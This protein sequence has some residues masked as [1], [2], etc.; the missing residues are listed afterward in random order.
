MALDLAFSTLLN[1]ASAVLFVALGAWALSLKPRRPITVAFGWFAI[2][3]GATFVYRNAG[4]IVGFDLENRWQ[5]P[6]GLAFYLAFVVLIWRLL[7][8]AD[9]RA[10]RRDVLALA[11]LALA[12]ALIMRLGNLSALWQDP[13]RSTGS[14]LREG[15]SWAAALVAPVRLLSGGG[16]RDARRQAGLVAAA[17]AIFDGAT[18]GEALWGL[19]ADAV[20]V[21]GIANVVLPAFV[22]VPLWLVVAARDEAD[23]RAARNV[24]WTFTAA[25]ILGFAFFP[26]TPPGELQ[27]AFR[28][29]TRVAMMAA[30]AYAILRHQVLGLDVRV[31]WT[32]SKSTVA[33]AF[34][35]VFFVASEGA[36][37]LFGADDQWLGLVAA[38]A[39]VFALAPLQRAADRLAERAVPSPEPAGARPLA[40]V[41]APGLAAYRA[42]VRA[43]RND[44]AVN[45]AEEHHLAEVAQHL[46]IGALDALRIRR[47][48]EVE[49]RVA[50]GGE[51]A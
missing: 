30:L 16:D 39:L 43:A 51:R 32:I 25:A 15:A 24:V 7:P 44:G 42:A 3:F 48:V 1:L 13:V 12:G 33:G 23:A 18:A 38:G 35:V 4:N 11:S 31:R 46:G 37:L 41:S 40:A 20:T 49:V 2:L 14:T 47:E 21:F 45:E 26:L 22:A 36:Q 50:A 10:R 34:V 8:L 9:A 5:W 19:S 6:F 17:V 27:N 28:G 29:V